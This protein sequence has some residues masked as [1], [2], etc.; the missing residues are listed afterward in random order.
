[1]HSKTNVLAVAVAI[2]VMVSASAH[3]AGA[4]L[5]APVYLSESIPFEADAAGEVGLFSPKAGSRQRIEDQC[6]LQ[7]KLA[8]AISEQAKRKGMTVVLTPDLETAQGRVLKIVI[9][10]AQ[11]NAWI[12]VKSLTLRGELRE[13]T[14]LVGSFV[15]REENM[16]IV[17]GTCSTLLTCGNKLA[18]HIA[19]WLKQ[20]KLKARLGEA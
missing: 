10:G 6:D 15:A 3:A 19:K 1:M 12:S 20:P 9:E 14:T 5:V 8:V 17:S 16:A 2:L 4:V 7:R 18:A 13:G 11:G